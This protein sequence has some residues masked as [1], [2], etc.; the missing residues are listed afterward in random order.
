VVLAY[1]PALHKVHTDAD[2][3]ENLPIPHA[4]QVDAPDDAETVPAVQFEHTEFPEEFAYVPALHKGQD[5]N[6]DLAE[7]FPIAHAV[8]IVAP[9]GPDGE[10]VPAKQIEQN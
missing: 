8:H 6:P 4:V 7:N 3:A 2:V 10:K 1:V 5:D 9:T